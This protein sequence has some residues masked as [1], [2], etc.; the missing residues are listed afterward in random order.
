MI[1]KGV[2]KLR[3]KKAVGLSLAT[4][5]LSSSLAMA[6]DFSDIADHWGAEAIKQ[7]VSEK[8]I[9]GYEDGTFRPENKITREEA[10][11]MIGRL[12][13]PQDYKEGHVGKVFS[14]VKDRY[15]A[16]FIDYLAD[17]G[18]LKGYED[19]TFRPTTEISREEF[20]TIVYRYAK[21]NE[22][23]DTDK[24]GKLDDMD[25]V[26][27]WAKEPVEVMIGNGIIK[28]MGDGTFKPSDKIKRAE[29]AQILF[30]MLKQDTG[31]YRVTN[32]KVTLLLQP[33]EKANPI[34][35]NS[36]L[37]K[38]TKVIIEGEEGDYLLVKP[39]G[40]EGASRGYALKK[41]FD[42]ETKPDDS[43][44]GKEMVAKKEIKLLT[45]P[46]KDA[47]LIGKNHTLP[48]GTIVKVEGEATEYYLVRPI[49]IVDASRGYVIKTDLVLK[50]DKADESKAESK[51]ADKETKDETAETE[52]PT[53]ENKKE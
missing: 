19:D 25:K 27:D 52:K 5:L 49:G 39:Y 43:V 45:Q 24:K 51:E 2:I 8:I 16:R 20:A 42:K 13:N 29:V 4:L 34:T 18:I 32:Q 23:I 41:Y 38:G 10:A 37:A 12:D 48:T 36:E 17:N 28:G 46:D 14:D 22:I 7:L 1:F 47:G 11:T 50:V 35:K 53:D 9:Y 21:K 30:G 26:S 40:V 6:V 31:R 44:I 33:N 15:S 3:L